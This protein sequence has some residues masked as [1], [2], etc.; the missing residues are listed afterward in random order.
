MKQ[1][2]G[3]SR[4]ISLVS[5]L[6]DWWKLHIVSTWVWS[7]CSQTLYNAEVSNSPICF[8]FLLWVFL[9]I[10]FPAIDSTVRLWPAPHASSSTDTGL[11]LIGAELLASHSQIYENSSVCSI[12]SI[13][14][15]I[16]FCCKKKNNKSKNSDKHCI[17]VN[18]PPASLP[19]SGWLYC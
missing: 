13:T 19:A 16:A 3:A 15:K 10:F 6:G 1:V 2:L 11:E 17:S 12:T 7:I 18:K 9:F 8:A 14:I 5:A 4:E